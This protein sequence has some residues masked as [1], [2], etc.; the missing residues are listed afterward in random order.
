MGQERDDPQAG[1]VRRAF[2]SRLI[3]RVSTAVA[4][5]SAISRCECTYSWIDFKSAIVK[6]WR[7]QTCVR[8][9]RISFAR[10]RV[11]GDPQAGGSRNLVGRIEKPEPPRQRRGLDVEGGDEL[12][13]GRNVARWHCLQQ[14]RAEVDTGTN[15]RHRSM[16]RRPDHADGNIAHGEREAGRHPGP[17]AAPR[18]ALPAVERRAG[19]QGRLGASTAESK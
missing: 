5:R 18:V 7:R 1:F 2:S 17:I 9:R 11:D 13:A 3:G 8:C 10:E 16:N 12:R 6:R 4:V 15:E 14:A 19:G